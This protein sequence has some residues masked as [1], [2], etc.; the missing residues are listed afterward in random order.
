MTVQFGNCDRGRCELQRGQTYDFIQKFKA[1][2]NADNLEAIGTG[3]VYGLEIEYD[4]LSDADACQF[5]SRRDKKGEKGKVCPLEKDVWYV[6]EKQ[7]KIRDNELR[8]IFHLNIYY[9]SF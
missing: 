3:R 2:R 5:I 4:E 9:N 1:P 7:F 8:V 6:Y